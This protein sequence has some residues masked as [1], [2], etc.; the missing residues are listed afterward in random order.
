MAFSRSILTLLISTSIITGCGGSS[1]SAPIPVVPDNTLPVTACSQ[2]L[3]LS[4]VTGTD[5]LEF[6]LETSYQVNQPGALIAKLT[7]KDSSGLVF[8]WQQ[9]AGTDLSLANNSS[10]ILN[11]T[12]SNTGEYQFKVTISG[13]GID[14]NQLITINVTNAQQISLSVNADHQVVEGNGVSVR[15]ASINGQMPT[16]VKWC[17]YSDNP[18]SL[19]LTKTERPLFIAPIVN[20]D[21]I[22][23]LRVTAELNGQTLTDDVHILITNEAGIT[24]PYFDQPVSRTYAYKPNS[25]YAAVLPKCV[26]SN[27]LDSS[28]R[29]NQLPLIGQQTS[30]PSIA[31]IMDRVVV[32]H[33]WMGKNFEQFL[34]QQDPNSDFITLLQSVTA[35][36]ISYDV[37]PSF[38]WVVTGAIYLDPD[39]LWLTAAERDTINEAP[40]YRSNFGNNLQF[41]MPWRY[42]K[43]NQYAYA[44]YPYETRTNRSVADFTPRLS[45]LLYHEL[46]HANDFF[47]RSTH[48]TLQGP[49][50]LE[51]FNRRSSS[52]ALVSDQLAIR[53][54]LQSSE[55]Y[56]LGTVSFKGQ[57]A[58]DIQKSYLPSDITTFFSQDNASDYYNYSSNREDAAMLFEEAFMSYRYS[59][60]RDV[61][62]T[63]KPENA[64]GSNITVDWGQRGRIGEANIKI[65]AQYVID[66]IM[67]E[68]ASQNLI[69][70]LS[71]PLQLT[72]GKSWTE[73]LV[74]N[75]AG[76]S[77][78][79]KVSQSTEIKALEDRPLELSGEQHR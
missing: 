66:E 21:S 2:P 56:S 31:N 52:N 10:P 34:Q 8:K 68:V 57:T 48:S 17:A 72:P 25:S 62:V 69:N 11:F 43:N 39:N 79:Q 13:S 30:A 35:I 71:K 19:D 6:L 65:R 14:I 76:A 42:V 40:D 5:N 16:N 1:D 29:I 36:I 50:L 4:T 74:V 37:R 27:K 7:N 22:V 38:Y 67:P 78:P 23:S 75:P 54:P 60:L 53:F 55:M 73:N 64:T 59:M 46:A 33:D 63:D 44:S 49:T 51:D 61:A 26:Y 24:S 9:M 18:I 15:L 58:N 47:P 28:C 45:S 32:S 77:S 12:P 20:K 70:S 3:E 41:L